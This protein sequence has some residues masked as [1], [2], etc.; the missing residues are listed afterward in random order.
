MTNVTTALLSAAWMWMWMCVSSLSLVVLKK[1]KK[2]STTGRDHRL[3]IILGD[4]KARER[5]ILFASFL[6]VAAA[7]TRKK[8]KNDGAV[9]ILF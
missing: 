5:K 8:G 3:H 7:L 4:E 9:E 2:A 1:K 6:L